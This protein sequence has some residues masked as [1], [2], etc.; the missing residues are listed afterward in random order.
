MP[1]S[2]RSSLTSRRLEAEHMVQPDSMA[3]DLSGEAM[4]AVRVGW[5][6]HAESLA[7]LHPNYQMRLP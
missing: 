6:L 2:A 5:W 3:G 4:A 7:G 1:R